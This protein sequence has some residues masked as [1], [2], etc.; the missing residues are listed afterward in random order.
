M[1]IA[2][3]GGDTS[4][5]TYNLAERL[6]SLTIDGTTVNYT[7][8]QD[9]IR[10]QKQIQ[11]GSSTVYLIDSYVTTGYAQILEQWVPSGRHP[12]V[13]CTIGNDFIGL[14]QPGKS[15]GGAGGRDLCSLRFALPDEICENI[16]GAEV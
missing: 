2:V 5:Y 8:N 4:N 11:G 12:D 15:P 3:T 7:Y 6:A 1:Q 14:R 9:G 13:T 16:I 10:V